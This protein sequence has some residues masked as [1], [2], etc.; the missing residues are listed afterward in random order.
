M[1]DTNTEKVLGIL[2][3]RLH[4]DENSPY[5]A[6]H[7]G[8][9]QIIGPDLIAHVKVSDVKGRT[10][11]VEVDHPA[12]SNIVMMRKKQ[13][14]KRVRDLFPALDIKFLQLRIKG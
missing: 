14:I 5:A 2:L 7:R 9:M 1:S 12:W 8:W 4:C 6:L 13:I 10:L 3:S 11:V